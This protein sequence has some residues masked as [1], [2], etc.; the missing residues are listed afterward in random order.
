MQEVWVLITIGVW[1]FD[2]F[3]RAV[4]IGRNGVLRAYVT[5]IDDDYLRVDVPGL[6][7][8]GHVYLY[9]P[10]LNWRVWESHPFSVIGHSSLAAGPGSSD[11]SRAVAKSSSEK[12]GP[13]VSEAGVGAASSS[14]SSRGSVHH[15]GPVGTT[16]YIRLRTGTTVPLAKMAG[17]PAGVAV[18]A[19]SSYGGESK[20]YP[21]G[22][23]A[24]PSAAYPNLI[25]IAGGVG[26]T[27]VLP[28]LS[29]AQSLYAPLGSKK[30]FWGVRASS[31]GLVDSV[32]GI[33]AATG[34][35]AETRSAPSLGRNLTTW[36]DV[37]VE[38]SVGERFDIRAVLENELKGDNATAGTTVF[39]CG[40]GAMADE[41]RS[42][43]TA[44]ARQGHVIRYVEEAFAW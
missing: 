43:V 31:Q 42:V 12:P 1:V 17:V 27:A 18:L 30:L 36:G 32:Q 15:H 19:E 23:H 28:I 29:S 33:V 2:W 9:F 20:L 35:G 21:G 26:I 8:H 4:R 25:A 37:D 38:I 40:P 13:D 24:Q 10:T 5:K 22:G 11:Q 14:A 39:V 7:A 34:V 44:L 3:L 16:L 6:D 41:V